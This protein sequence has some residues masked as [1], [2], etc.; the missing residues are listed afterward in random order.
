M[1]ARALAGGKG[2]AGNPRDPSGAALRCHGCNSV[3]HLIANCPLRKGKGKGKKGKGKSFYEETEDWGEDNLVEQYE[4]S[5]AGYT[6][7]LYGASGGGSP[8]TINASEQAPVQY[9]PAILDADQSGQGTPP[10]PRHITIR[11]QSVLIMI[12]I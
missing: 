10:L 4:F 7:G 12:V 1:P 3:A 2:K 5:Y 9:F 11:S 6:E 8:P